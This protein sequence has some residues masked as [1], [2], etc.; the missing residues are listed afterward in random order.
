M[1]LLRSGIDVY[2]PLFRPHSRVDLVVVTAERLLRV[3]CKTSYRRGE[4]IVFRTC[5]NTGNVEQDYRGDVDAFGV[6]SPELEQAFLVPISE[7]AT[8]RC[9]LRLGPA[10]N[11]QRKGTRWAADYLVTPPSS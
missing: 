9:H 11:G 8:R 7:V 4:V 10:A 2:V 5:S 6:W 3:Q 1:V